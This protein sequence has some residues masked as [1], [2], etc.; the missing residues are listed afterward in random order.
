MNIQLKPETRRFI[1]DFVAHEITTLTALDP[2]G[3]DDP[4]PGSPDGH[5]Q[6]W[7]GPRTLVCAHCAKVLWS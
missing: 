3:I 5:Y 1:E 6:L 4:C 7:D 2:F